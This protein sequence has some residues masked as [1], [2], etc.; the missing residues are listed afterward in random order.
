MRRYYVVRKGCGH[1]RM[2]FMGKPWKMI[3]RP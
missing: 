3:R 2:R 1:R